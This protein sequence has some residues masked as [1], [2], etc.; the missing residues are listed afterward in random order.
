LVVGLA[1]VEAV[2]PGQVLLAI[3]LVGV[4]RELQISPRASCKVDRRAQEIK[5]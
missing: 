1:V 2:W 5:Y 3:N 4:F